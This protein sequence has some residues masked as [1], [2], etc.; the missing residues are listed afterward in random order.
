[1][2]EWHNIKV[3]R[4]IS[5]DLLLLQ[6]QF[7]I[8]LFS[9]NIISVILLVSIYKYMSYKEYKGEIDELTGIMG[10]RMFLYHCEKAQKVNS[11]DLKKQV[12]FYL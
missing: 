1:M 6:I 7:L 2:L 3:S 11:S 5:A 9:L 4:T 12:G 8:S 10:R